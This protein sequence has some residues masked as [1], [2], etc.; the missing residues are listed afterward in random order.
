MKTLILFLA[1]IYT[2]KAQ[3][4]LYRID[5]L[6]ESVHY[7]GEET[8]QT[9][10]NLYRPVGKTTRG[11]IYLFPT[12][13]GPSPLEKTTARYFARRGFAVII[14][15][16]I[17]LELNINDPSVE[18]LDRDY[19][20]PTASALK[21]IEAADLLLESS[22]EL[23]VFAL[24]AS[25]GGI[26]TVGLTSESSRIKAAWFVVAGGNFPHVY[27]SSQVDKIK[28][29]RHNHM[30]KLGLSDAKD[31]ENYLRENLKNDPL[32]SCAK[33]N[34]PIVQVIALE[35]DKV[36]TSTQWELHRACPPHEIFQIKGGH[37][38]GAST[39]YFYREKILDFFSRNL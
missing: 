1:T 31:Y 36:P 14:P 32:Y 3:A 7:L 37:V 5:H 8:F 30:R 6:K 22:R 38:K 18:Q 2:F 34:V 23:P 27:A 28:I 17:G 11:I 16:P 15:D 39:I 35:D 29:L 9:E 24:G 33:I 10:G 4:T 19:F 12:I 25:Q 21:L 13:T 26:R 20:K